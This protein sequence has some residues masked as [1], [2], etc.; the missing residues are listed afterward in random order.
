M[1]PSSAAKRAAPIANPSYGETKSWR[2]P[3]P[4][5]PGGGFQREKSRRLWYTS[6]EWVS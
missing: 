5:L 6:K 2:S 4:V 1:N 3:W